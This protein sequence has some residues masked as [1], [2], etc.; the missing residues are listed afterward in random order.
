MQLYDKLQQTVK[1]KDKDAYLNFIH[2]DAVFV[3]H[4]SG[5]QFSKTEAESLVSGMIN[6]IK[7]IQEFSRLIYEN[8]EIMVPHKFNSYP[9][10]TR[11]VVMGVAMKKMEKL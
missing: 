6:N 8:K 4:K 7:F 3:F 1:D 10:D 2:E 9:D 11:E 5:N